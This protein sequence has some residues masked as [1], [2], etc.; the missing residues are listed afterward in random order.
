MFTKIEI[1]KNRLL[2]VQGEPSKFFEFP[3]VWLRDN[4]QCE[5]CFDPATTSRK[6]DWETL[7]FDKANLRDAK[8]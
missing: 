4:C 1:V 7:F 2:L 3:L 5:E 8:V 6:I